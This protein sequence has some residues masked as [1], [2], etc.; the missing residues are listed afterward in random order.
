MTVEPHGQVLTSPSK[1]RPDHY[2]A[3]ATAMR[4]T[5]HNA[6]YYN[7]AVSVIQPSTAILRYNS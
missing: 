5:M 2:V 7:I 3:I 1:S 6:S 4:K